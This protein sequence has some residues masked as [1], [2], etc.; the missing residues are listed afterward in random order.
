MQ[1]LEE[2]K[3]GQAQDSTTVAPSETPA[4]P[5]TP[6]TVTKTVEEIDAMLAAARR[7][8]IAQGQSAASKK[9][10]AL[11]SK[12]L[13]P[14]RPLLEQLKQAS[15]PAA[16]PATPPPATPSKSKGDEGGKEPT[17][18]QVPPQVEKQLHDLQTQL[19]SVTKE[20]EARAAREKESEQA[21][22]KSRAV[23]EA[24]TLFSTIAGIPLAQARVLAKAKMADGEI[25]IRDNKQ[26]VFR[27][28]EV[29]DDDEPEV[30][31]L[32]TGIEKWSRSPEANEFRP[33]LP[34]GAGATAGTKPLPTTA[35]RTTPDNKD[36]SAGQKWGQAV[37]KD[38]QRRM[39]ERSSQ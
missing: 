18:V 3:S 14:F 15:P 32:K 11:V 39:Q 1:T 6:T 30:L 21:L 8:G 34:R 31:P 23:D 24:A 10:E 5:A 26:V 13:E 25:V 36:L 12:A 28:G 38:S 17:A 4:A 19:K 37:Q 35:A 27:T 22:L 9:A 29:L 33:A 7:D 16:A 20:N 2:N